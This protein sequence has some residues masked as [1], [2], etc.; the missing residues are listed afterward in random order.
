MSSIALFYEALKAQPVGEAHAGGPKSNRKMG[1][2]PPCR[3]STY[4]KRKQKHTLNH[5]LDTL[6]KCSPSRRHSSD[7]SWEVN[8][9]GHTGSICVLSLKPLAEFNLGCQ[10]DGI[11]SHLGDVPLGM[12]VRLS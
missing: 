4:R 12:W 9:W 11:G 8:E 10:L 6:G 2:F 7:A 5:V 3:V 1:C